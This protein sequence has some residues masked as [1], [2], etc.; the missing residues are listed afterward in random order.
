MQPS[1]SF[2]D[3]IIMNMDYALKTIT[4]ANPITERSNP[5]E[6]AT[7]TDLSKSEQKISAALMRVNHAGE[8]S[9]QGLYQG[10]AL[11]AKLPKVKAQMVRAAME[12]NDHLDWCKKRCLELNSHTSYL[13]P[14][15]YMGSYSIGALA[16][17][18][19]DKWSLGFVAETEHQVVKH[20]DEHLQL[21][22]EKDKKSTQILQQMREDELHHAKLAESSGAAKLP[23]PIKSLMS[24]SSKVMTKVAYYL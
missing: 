14:F 1:Y 18:A 19:G 6:N 16:G 8:V 13:S 22:P 12:E 10:Q 24:L 23:L 3:N 11:T 5:A 20:L 2:F 15:W 7:E 17:A 4:G 21:L 9:A